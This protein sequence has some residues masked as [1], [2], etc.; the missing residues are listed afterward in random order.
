MGETLSLDPE[1]DMWV[2]TLRKGKQP[3]GRLSD[4]KDLRLLTETTYIE[5][6][7]DESE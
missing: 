4:D 3:T 1:R 5:P 6:N 2:N 7:R